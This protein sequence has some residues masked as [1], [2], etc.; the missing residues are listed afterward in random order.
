MCT[1]DNQIA[2]ISRGQMLFLTGDWEI[3]PEKLQVK[4]H[5]STSQ[6]I[7][8]ANSQVLVA[9]H[10]LAS[11]TILSIKCYFKKKRQQQIG[12]RRS[13][14][15]WDKLVLNK[16]GLFIPLHLYYFNETIRLRT[17]TRL[18]LSVNGDH[19][20]SNNDLNKSS[21]DVVLE[22][23]LQKRFWITAHQQPR[24][25]SNPKPANPQALVDV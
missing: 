12:H 20:S 1:V 8:Q 3:V 21:A 19:V 18:C 11:D 14:T 25:I 10:Q 15:M 17:T 4:S 5:E 22:K 9:D 7:D 23:R 6:K 2:R 24:K 13:Q 16:L